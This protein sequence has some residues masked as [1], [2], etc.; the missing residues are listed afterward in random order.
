MVDPFGD[1]VMN[2]RDLP[3]DSWRQRHDTCKV[4]IAR[5]CLASGL[6]HDVEVFGLFADLLPAV[7]FQ[8]GGGDLE[9]ARARQGLVPDFRLRLPTPEGPSDSLAELKVI[10]AGVTWHP[11]GRA[12][13]GV[14]RRAA[15][16]PALYNRKLAR[17]DRRFH[18]TVGNE[19]GPLVTRLQSYGDLQCLVV[20]P[21]GNGSKHLHELVHT[22]AESRLAT[23]TR[24]RGYEGSDKELGLVTGQIRRSLSVDF[25][26]AQALCLFSRLAHLGDGAQA[27]AVRRQQAGREEEGRRRDQVAHYLAHIRGRGV[28]RAG[29]VFVQH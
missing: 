1:S 24:A 16:L 20:G 17:Y 11:R 18:G 2:C 19:A 23:R 3:G 9:W 27:A 14:D 22:L 4:A 13:T 15:G 7:A 21:W 26:R 25:V 12:G 5:E 8:Q 10:S 29:E 6:P 28:N